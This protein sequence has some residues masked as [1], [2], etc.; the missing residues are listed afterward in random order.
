MVLTVPNSEPVA[1]SSRLQPPPSP[2]RPLLPLMPTSTPTPYVP[3]THPGCVLCG[4]VASAASQSRTRSSFSHSDDGSTSSTPRAGSPARSPVRSQPMI[5]STSAS[6][7]ASGSAMGLG[8][9]QTVKVGDREI[10]YRDQDITVFPAIG[11]ERLCSDGRHLIIVMNQH[12]ESVYN[13]VSDRRWHSCDRADCQ[14]PSDIP[15]LS[16]M[17]DTARQF[18]S[19]LPSTSASGDSESAKLPDLRVGFVGP[20]MRE[21]PVHDTRIAANDQATRDVLTPTYMLTRC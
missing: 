7:S 17:L 13:L 6:A 11:K 12:V 10:V 3:P 8:L 18:L 20:I 21:L 9:G 19:S 4:L 15:L 14:G 5:P 1:S 16:H 2:Q